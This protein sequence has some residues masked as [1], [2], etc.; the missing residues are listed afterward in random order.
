MTNKDVPRILLVD[1]VRLF[2]ELEKVYLRRHACEVLTADS[3]EAALQ[4]A[5]VETLHL[6]VLDD[7]MPGLGGIDTSRRLNAQPRTANVP[8]LMTSNPGLES[9][10]LQAGADGFVGKPILQSEFISKVRQLLPH[11]E[12]RA[13]ERAFVSIEVEVEVGGRTIR[14]DSRDLSVSG[15]FIKSAAEVSLGDRVRLR[16]QLQGLERPLF[17]AGEVRN[18]ILPSPDSRMSPGFGVRFDGLPAADQRA[19]QD[20]VRRIEG[21]PPEDVQGREAAKIPG[22]GPGGTTVA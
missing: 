3:G 6:I 11:L 22:Q 15:M 21:V 13:N 2:R 16:F 7:Q 5:A 1:D 10:C 14:G 9:G 20:Y 19:I 12:E 8:V 17:L 4:V 18:R